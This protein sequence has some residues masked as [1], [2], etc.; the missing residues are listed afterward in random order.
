[1]DTWATQSIQNLPLLGCKDTH[2]WLLNQ[3]R[4]NIL[5]EKHFL[6]LIL[7]FSKSLILVFFQ[8]FVKLFSRLIKCDFFI[9]FKHY[10]DLLPFVCLL[11]LICMRICLDLQVVSEFNW[12][13][14]WIFKMNSNYY[15][16][17][18]V[19]SIVN[20][21][22]RLFNHDKRFWETIMNLK[23]YLFYKKG[24]VLFFHEIVL[25]AF[26][27]KSTDICTPFVW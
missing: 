26:V 4:C 16:K 18:S 27:S 6:I 14:V 12:S 19:S 21:K 25:I 23:F 5:L 1:M 10:R 22:W 8:N 11:V 20:L 15:L 7:S 24:Q 17:S 13:F 2:A 9:L 3:K